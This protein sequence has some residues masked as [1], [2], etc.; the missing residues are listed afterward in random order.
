V[1][2][3]FVGEVKIYPEGASKTSG[4]EPSH[5]L[6]FQLGWDAEPSIKFGELCY[7]YKLGKTRY[8]A[9]ANYI[10]TCMV[11]DKADKTIQAALKKSGAVK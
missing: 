3:E 9:S 10:P 7:L 5:N 8:F 6:T 2:P 11:L 1:T 4:Y